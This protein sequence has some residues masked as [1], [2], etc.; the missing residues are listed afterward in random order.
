VLLGTTIGEVLAFGVMLQLARPGWGPAWRDSLA[1]SAALA[2]FPAALGAFLAAIGPSEHMVLRF[3]LAIGYLALLAIIAW[4][5][6]R[7]LAI[8]SYR[9]KAAAVMPVEVGASVAAADLK[10]AE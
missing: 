7:R 1:W 3:E 2:L 9:T 5:G 10:A 8:T 4:F 6:L